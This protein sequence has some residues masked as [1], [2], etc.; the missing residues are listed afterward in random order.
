MGTLECGTAGKKKYLFAGSIMTAASLLGARNVADCSKLFVFSSQPVKKNGIR[1]RNLL[2][3][4]EGER[5]E[6]ISPL[7]LICWHEG[8]GAQT[9]GG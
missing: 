8:R 6:D 5:C 1:F 7:L 9:H 2:F 3:I 4:S